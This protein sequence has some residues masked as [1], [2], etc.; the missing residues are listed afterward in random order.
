MKIREHSYLYIFTI[1]LLILC[2]SCATK[3]PSPYKKY[4]K[5]R[6]VVQPCDCYSKNKTVKKADFFY[7]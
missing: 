3:K 1:V 6:K 7:A 5:K 2:L 4:K